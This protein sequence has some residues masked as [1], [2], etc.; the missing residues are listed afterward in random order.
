M[1]DVS[2]I[3]AAID[4]V[5]DEGTHDGYH[6]GPDA[7]SWSPP[8]DEPVVRDPED[9]IEELMLQG[10]DGYAASALSPAAYWRSLTRETV[11]FE[12]DPFTVAIEAEIR[13]TFALLIED[14][15]YRALLPSRLAAIADDLN[16]HLDVP[17]MRLTWDPVS[18]PEPRL[19]RTYDVRAA[20]P[21]PELAPWQARLLR[22]LGGAGFPPV[23]VIVPPVP[24]M[25]APDLLI[26]D[27]PSGR[28]PR[29]FLAPAIGEA[30]AEL[31]AEVQR[32][33]EAA[34]V[35]LRHAEPET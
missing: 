7:M 1:K 13:A 35:L 6:S 34:L 8:W 21:L 23:T 4:G 16:G 27:D 15:I 9:A 12:L 22:A 31:P 17:G 30:T 20:V 2:G 32:V 11:P 24:G 10:W 19:T 14:E 28:R 3:L 18:V 5:L 29:Q 26:I 25:R 33:W